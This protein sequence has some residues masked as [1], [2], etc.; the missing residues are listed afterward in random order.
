MRNRYVA[1]IAAVAL[2]AGAGGAYTYTQDQA[3]PH[4]R[5]VAGSAPLDTSARYLSAHKA[6]AATKHQAQHA[7]KTAARKAAARQAARDGYER[8]TAPQDDGRAPTTPVGQPCDG[9]PD[10][11][12]VTQPDGTCA[13]PAHHDPQN[14]GY[15]PSQPE[16]TAMCPDGAATSPGCDQLIKGGE[17]NMQPPKCGDGS[18]PAYL[19]AHGLHC[20]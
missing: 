1:A 15:H 12:H 18:T 6:S 2:M 11:F 19:R 8:A 10:S 7:A 17:P 3:A 20:K 16:I 13:G 9:D 5:V 4:T 14:Y